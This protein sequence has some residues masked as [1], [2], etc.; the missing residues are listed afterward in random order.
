[1]N[2]DSTVFSTFFVYC[3]RLNAIM[4]SPLTSTGKFISD[5][6]AN[7]AYGHLKINKWRHIED[8]RQNM[9]TVLK[10]CEERL[11]ASRLEN[12]RSD[13]EYLASS[14]LRISQ[15]ELRLQK[16]RLLSEEEASLLKS[17]VELRVSRMPLQ[18]ITGIAPFRH[19]DLKVGKGVLIPR[20]E[21]EMLVDIALEDS[22]PDGNFCDIGT[23]S[24]A[25]ALSIAQERPDSSVAASDSSPEALK[26]ARENLAAAGLKNVRILQSDLFSAYGPGDKFDVI[27]ANLPYIRK[28]EYLRLPD[29]IRSFEPEAALSAGDDGLDVI[30]KFI[31]CAWKFLL[32]GGKAVLEISPEQKDAICSLVSAITRYGPPT[33]LPDFNRKTRFCVLS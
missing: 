22:R 16:D 20:P 2:S 6:T 3:L 23:G 8:M 9:Q 11:L 13:A 24:G 32:P 33:F 10:H 26:Y 4:R 5:K 27:T 19:L 15:L 18:Y 1:M 28:D 7:P 17:Y 31:E 25:I 30:G 14:V 21:T 12:P 29:E